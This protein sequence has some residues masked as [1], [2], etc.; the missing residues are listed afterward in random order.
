MQ[1]GS[2][3]WGETNRAWNVVEFN[4]CDRHSSQVEKGG[5]SNLEWILSDGN[6]NFVCTVRDGKMGNWNSIAFKV[7]RIK[8]TILFTDPI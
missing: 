5:V 7:Y 8:T 3:N 4:F 2:Q 1:D 6:L